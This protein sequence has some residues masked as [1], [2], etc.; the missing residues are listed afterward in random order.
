M[1]FIGGLFAPFVGLI[2]LISMMSRFGTLVYEMRFAKT[3][4]KDKSSSHFHYLNFFSYLF[5]RLLAFLNLAPNWKGTKR[6]DEMKKTV[7]NLLDVIHL[8]RR[9]AFLEKT[10]TV[11]FENHQLKGLHLLKTTTKQEAD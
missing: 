10:M 1:S 4:F 7:S 11:L 8:Q 3:F 9:I 6:R 2:S 5:Y